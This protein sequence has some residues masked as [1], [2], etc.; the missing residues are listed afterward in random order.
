MD[1]RTADRIVGYLLDKYENSLTNAPAGETYEKL[2][3][4]NKNQPLPHYQRLYSEVRK[5]LKELGLDL[6]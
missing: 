1:L 6:Q 5:E 2:Y 3:D 4:L